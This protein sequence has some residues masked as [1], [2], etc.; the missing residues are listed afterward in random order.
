MRRVRLRRDA[1]E[2]LI[3]IYLRSLEYFGLQQAE[4]YQQ[5]LGDIFSLIADQPMMGQPSDDIVPG[6]RRHVWKAHV[7]YYVVEEDGIR[8]LDILGA[9]RDPVRAIR[10]LSDEDAG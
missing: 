9:G 6:T 8:I 7:I 4:R 1:E 3:D 10:P 2:S 5:G